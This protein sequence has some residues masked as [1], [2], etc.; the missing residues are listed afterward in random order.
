MGQSITVKEWCE[1]Y[2]AER[3]S[4]WSD[5]TRNSYHYLV[6]KHIVPGIGRNQLKQLTT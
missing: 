6:Q 4:D 5:V 3:E 1:Q 2:L